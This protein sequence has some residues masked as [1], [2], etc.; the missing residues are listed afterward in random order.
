MKKIYLSILAIIAAITLV[1]GA[2]Y[3]VFSNKV[4]SGPNTFA[5]GNADLKLRHRTDQAWADSYGGA[6]WDNLYPGWSDS[7]DVYLKNNSSSPI[8][9]KALPTINITSYSTGYLWDEV[10]MEITWSDGTHSTGE[11]SLRAWRENASIYLEPTLAQGA[12]AGPW[13]IKFRIPATAGNEI[14]D[15]SIVFDL[16]FDGIQITP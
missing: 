4:I 1:G 10:L 2:T 5:T 9:L 3:A 16:I 14:K 15:G 6:N 13:V 11:Y 7:Y 8:T 12:D